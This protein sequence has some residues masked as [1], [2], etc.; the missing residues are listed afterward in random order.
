MW[1]VTERIRLQI[2]MA[3]ISGV[4]VVQVF[5]KDASM[6]SRISGQKWLHVQNFKHIHILFI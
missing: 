5:D 2:Q 4:Q 3:E 6:L 1:V